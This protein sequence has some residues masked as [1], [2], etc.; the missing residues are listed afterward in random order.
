MAR[1]TAPNLLSLLPAGEWQ[2]V[3]ILNTSP[4]MMANRNWALFAKAKWLRHGGKDAFVKFIVLA[5]GNAGSDTEL[6]TGKEHLQ[7]LEERLKSVQRQGTAAPIVALLEIR[8]TDQG[9]LVAMEEVRPLRKVID[10]GEA[11]DLSAKVLVD[12]NPEG[13]SACRWLHY[14]I[15]P[16]N[17]GVTSGGQCV[18]IDPESFYL[19]ADGAFHVSV[20]AWKRD[21]VPE[22]LRH[23]IDECHAAGELPY[24]QAI[25]KM[26]FEVALAA[27]ECILGPMPPE[28]GG[29]TLSRLDRWLSGADIGD[30]GVAFWSRVIRDAVSNG[31][32]TPLQQLA[33]QLQE[34]LSA[35]PSLQHA[36]RVMTVEQEDARGPSSIPVEQVTQVPQFE[37]ASAWSLQWECLRP[38]AYAL[39]AGQLDRT[40]IDT[41]RLAIERLTREYP[42]ACEVWDELLLVVISYEKDPR[43]ALRAVNDAVGAVPDNREFRRLQQL[44]QV[45]AGG[46]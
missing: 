46:K 9:L 30:A 45:W 31:S 22:V 13:G 40:G 8:L 37:A 6:V 4:G 42:E 21:R 19:T 3:R 7:L 25:N 43:A 12:L 29:L 35:K 39:R 18:F 15:C 24:D 1:N 41:Y 27:A 32:M 44:V 14:D 20:P 2:N 16:M 34:A 38:A 28:R 11:Y 23:A 33:E 36:P 5:S 26:R 17:I 10:G